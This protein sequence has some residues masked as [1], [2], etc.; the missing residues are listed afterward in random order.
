ML[1]SQ[2]RKCAAAPLAELRRD[3]P[4]RGQLLV[5]AELAR[6][7]ETV[8]AA[9]QAVVRALERAQQHD[10][11]DD[12]RLLTSELVT[13]AVMHGSGDIITVILRYGAGELTISVTDN[14]TDDLPDPRVASPDAEN[15]R[16]MLLVRA[17]G[18]RWGVTVDHLADVKH[19]WVCL[20]MQ[21]QPA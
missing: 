6:D 17:L 9:R 13:N 15:G 3:P 5:H 16:G 18:V 1:M 21:E 7:P 14:A 4:D 8:S 10:L 12:A 19:T 2:S 11:A 20:P